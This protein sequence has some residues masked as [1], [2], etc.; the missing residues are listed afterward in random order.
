MRNLKTIFLKSGISLLTITA[1]SL[2]LEG[3]EQKLTSKE[4][5]LL[6]LLFKNKNAVLDRSEALLNVWGNDSY[7]KCPQH[8]CLHDQTKKT[9]EV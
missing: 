4:A 5:D 2:Y 3:V 1:N 7:F 8:G 6:R 9:P